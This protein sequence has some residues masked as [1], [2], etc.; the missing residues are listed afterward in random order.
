[1]IY[2]LNLIKFIHIFFRHLVESFLKS[3]VSIVC[4]RYAY[5]GI[6][7]SVGAQASYITLLVALSF[8]VVSY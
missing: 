5:S 6:A 2:F 8:F 4:D 1:M 3:G 7:Y